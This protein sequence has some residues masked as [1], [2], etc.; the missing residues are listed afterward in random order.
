MALQLKIFEQ[1]LLDLGAQQIFDAEFQD[2]L[3]TFYIPTKEA[4]N[5][6]SPKSNDS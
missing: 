5:A 6:V 2:R 1:I 3:Y 4:W